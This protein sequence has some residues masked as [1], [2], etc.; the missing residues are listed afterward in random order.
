MVS[1]VMQKGEGA[2]YADAL[3]KVNGMTGATITGNGLN[4]ML[5]DY[6]LLYENYFKSVTKSEQ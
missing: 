3:H 6:L 4:D 2:D 5:L 1:V